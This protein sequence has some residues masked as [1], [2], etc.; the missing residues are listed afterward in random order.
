MRV[1]AGSAGGVP[2]FVPKTDLRPTMDQVRA[3]VFSALGE[4]VVGARVLDLFAGTGALGIEALSRGAASVVFVEKE[5]RAV[6][7]IRRNLDKTRL[8]GPTATVQGAEVFAALARGWG[9]SGP[10]DL[11]FADP[12]YAVKK[13]GADDLGARLLTDATLPTMLTPGGLLVL[14]K[15]PGQA[16]PAEM[17][18]QPIRQRRYGG[19]EVVFLELPSSSSSPS[20]SVADISKP[21]AS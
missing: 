13:P 6:E 18:W 12:P 14:E 7:T 8:A 16:L 1:I 19:T 4:R 20:P 9:V 21:D 17:T 5:R 2:L 15:V 3:A 10:F 11:V